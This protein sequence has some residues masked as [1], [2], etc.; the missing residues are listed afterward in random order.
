MNTTT[1]SFPPA[2]MPARIYSLEDLDA[3]LQ[4]ANALPDWPEIEVKE[5]LLCRLAGVAP[6]DYRALLRI[7]AIA[8]EDVV[9]LRGRHEC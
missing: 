8:V 6:T 2:P 3:A 1:E 7:L 9:R 4:H 5:A